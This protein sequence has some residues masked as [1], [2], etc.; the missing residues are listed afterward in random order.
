MVLSK[1]LVSELVSNYE[2]KLLEQIKP[3]KSRS[4]DLSESD[5]REM[6]RHVP[7]ELDY[8]DWRNIVWS[9]V[10]YLG[11]NGEDL[12]TEWSPDIKDKG[13]HLRS[14]VLRCDG[15][16]G[17][18]C[19]IKI[20]TIHGYRLPDKYRKARTPGQVAYEDIFNNGKHYIAIAKVLYKY[21]GKYYEK[22]SPD[23][24]IKLIADYFDQY[25]TDTTNKTAF[26]TESKILEAYK[27][28]LF[29]SY[30]DPELINPPGIN[31]KNGYLK[32]KFK[33]R[34]PIWKL[35]P[36]SPDIYHTYI[37]DFEYES[38][39]NT[40]TVK[41][42]LN[43]I[44]A[45]PQLTIFLRTV[46]AA[47]DLNMIRRLQGRSVR[48]LILFGVGANGKDTLRVWIEL[49]FGNHGL[50]SVGLRDFI[51]ADSGSRFGL[52]SLAT[53]VINW[54]S[55]N[56]VISLDK[57]QTLKNFATGDPITIE[58]K[59][60]DGITIKPKSVGIF[61]VNETPYVSSTLEAISGRYAF[62]D[63]P[64]KFVSKPNP[65]NPNEKQ[66][67]PKYKEDPEF[68]K[69]RI[70]PGLL[71]L[72]I[73]SFEDLC[74]EGID[75]SCT[76][77]T[78]ESVR[79]DSNHFYQFTQ[80][81]QLVPCPLTEGSTPLEIYVRYEAWCN[82]NHLLESHY[83]TFQQQ[84]LRKTW[85]HPSQ[86]DKCVTNVR[87]LTKRLKKEFPELKITRTHDGRKIG[88]KFLTQTIY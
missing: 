17:I 34:K 36:H 67:N 29:R 57:V 5:I 64:N 86:Y 19:L 40:D 56:D 23:Y 54:S 76:E 18:G 8:E 33:S 58:K 51:K 7:S 27:F 24:C 39:A 31:L 46:S 41:Q 10:G 9:V 6:L 59:H 78:I 83:S 38:D 13:K 44:L 49:L 72:L 71:I 20:A 22:M 70:L 88:L 52:Y 14:L 15:T 37:G 82:D 45:L 2:K 1:A 35:I 25:I 42:V 84:D 3:H 61:N 75:F 68:I 4:L 85:H 12:I 11:I 30:V 26:A 21:N 80:E 48:I 77:N 43:D 16:I 81:T 66:G 62:I 53:S 60:K 47:F 73:E 32:L 50:T 28:V 63:F 65:S 55:E 79:R 87:E 74:T 69:S